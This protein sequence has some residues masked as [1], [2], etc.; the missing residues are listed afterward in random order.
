[1]KKLLPVFAVLLVWGTS[2]I[3]QTPGFPE[4][5]EPLAPDALKAALADKIFKVT[6]AQGSPWRVQFNSNGYF[7]VNASSYSNSG[8]WGTKDS[9]LCQETGK[10]PGCNEIRSKDSR[11]YLKRD[12]GEVVAMEL[13]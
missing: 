7:F 12:S 1:M 3:A 2:A 11:L 10:S 9:S 5:A 6:P 8:K 13:Q 4:G